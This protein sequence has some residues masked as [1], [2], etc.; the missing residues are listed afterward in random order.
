M[1]LPGLRVRNLALKSNRYQIGLRDSPC[2]GLKRVPRFSET[3]M[4]RSDETH[5]CYVRQPQPPRRLAW[6]LDSSARRLWSCSCNI[7]LADGGTNSLLRPQRKNALAPCSSMCVQS[8]AVAVSSCVDSA[9]Y[10]RC[11][12]RT[13]AGLASVSTPI[14][15]RKRLAVRHAPAGAGNRARSRR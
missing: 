1:W 8:C 5:L 3:G 9:R 15:R 11:R 10:L 14:L 4:C 7:C 13:A 12:A 6:Q 2:A